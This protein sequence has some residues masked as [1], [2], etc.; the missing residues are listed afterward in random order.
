MRGKSVSVLLNLFINGNGTKTKI[1]VIQHDK[2]SQK[3]VNISK[4]WITMFT[5]G[6][7]QLQTRRALL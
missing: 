3:S 2:I 6:S 7:A 1:N 4:K 5:W